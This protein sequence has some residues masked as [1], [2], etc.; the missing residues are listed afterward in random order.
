MK[1]IRWKI[2]STILA[3]ILLNNPKMTNGVL[4]DLMQSATLTGDAYLSFVTSNV[5]DEDFFSYFETVTCY[6]DE[7][8]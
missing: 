2:P 1:L 7:Q 6:G 5:L 3:A 8:L 4:Q